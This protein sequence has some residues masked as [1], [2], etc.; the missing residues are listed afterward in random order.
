[1][2]ELSVVAVLTAPGLP[3][4]SPADILQISLPL[5]RSI[6]VDYCSS[7]SLPCRDRCLYGHHVLGPVAVAVA[8]ATVVVAA[9]AGCCFPLGLICLPWQ[10]VSARLLLCA[11]S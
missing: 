1:M 7:C 11:E 10:F 5:C 3:D 4:S 9:A 8:S 6:V 2:I